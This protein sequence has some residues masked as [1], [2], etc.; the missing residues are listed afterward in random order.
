[1]TSSTSF[2][3]FGAGVS[4]EEAFAEVEQILTGRLKEVQEELDAKTADLESKVNVVVDVSGSGANGRAEETL[5]S[6]Q[7]ALQKTLED[8]STLENLVR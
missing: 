8:I 2:D 4:P 1:M 5:E 7:A 6:V 3:P